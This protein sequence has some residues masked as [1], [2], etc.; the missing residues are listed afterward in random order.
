M[1]NT[2]TQTIENLRRFSHEAMATTFEVFIVHKDALYAEQAAFAAFEELD[3]IENNLSC[4]IPNSD[5]SRI[6]SFGK[7]GPLLV[8]LSVLECLK[9]SLKMRK[10]TKGAF[11]VTFDSL[12]KSRNMLKLSEADHTVE[13]KAEGVKIDLGAIGKGFA[14][15]K[16]AELLRQWS[17]DT[18]LIS[19]GG[20]TIVPI[21]TPA[22]MK[23][24]PV[25]ISGPQGSEGIK[26]KIQ[27]A[28][29][30]LGASGIQKGPHIIDPRTGK[31]P[32]GKI[33]AWATAKTGAVADAL[34]TAFMV[35]PLKEIR[36]FCSA[37]RDTSAFVI[38][39]GKNKR[40]RNRV[41]SF[42]NW[43]KLIL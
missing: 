26:L 41:S 40:L 34:S 21:G 4:F 20:S 16:M 42:A 25:A 3:R 24:W 17:I 12:R 38:L 5:I 18:A 23:G 37:H 8:G 10:Q 27:L 32:T 13:L 30:A 2:D 31:S 33:A 43:N 1:L 39:P 22:D 35:M 14:L 11:D 15:D 28:R 29:F 9:I 6:N 19:A 7:A 36:A